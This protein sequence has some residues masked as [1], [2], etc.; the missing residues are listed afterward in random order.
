MQPSQSERLR[1]AVILSVNHLRLRVSTP[2]VRRV[3]R[4]LTVVSLLVVASGIYYAWY[5]ISA[6]KLDVEPGYIIAAL[7]TY[8]LTYAM[9]TIG[10]HTLTRQ[11]FEPLPL[12]TNA[13]AVASSNLVKYLPTIGWY[14]ANRVHFYSERKIPSKSVIAASFSEL[15]IMILSGSLF[16]V[17]WWTGSIS[18][19]LLSIVLI[20]T[21]CFILV[22]VYSNTPFSAWWERRVR[23]HVVVNYGF[24]RKYFYWF[25]VVL[26]YS[27]TW[28]VGVCFLWLVLR[29]F[30]N[31]SISDWM[32]LFQVWIVAGL[33][34]YIISISLGGFGFAREL[35][36]TVLL[37]YTWSLP[38]AVATAILVKLLLTLGEISCSAV[39]LAVQYYLKTDDIQ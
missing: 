32:I 37:S 19:G 16:Y 24:D 35:T 31:I 9:H 13:K 18:W 28:L 15:I 8:I 11:F 17:V 25:P 20:L 4:L 5:E 29:S 22:M 21:S 27:M 39:V 38:I 14:I 33:A 12:R 23:G 1:Q 36:L 30:T 34:S 2:L 7:V 3:W 10:W 26:W 6:V